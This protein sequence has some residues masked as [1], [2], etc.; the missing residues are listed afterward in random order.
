MNS[1]EY[2]LFYRESIWRYAVLACFA[3]KAENFT[4]MEKYKSEM[5]RFIKGLV[6]IMQQEVVK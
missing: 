3:Q 5:N 6:E 1:W 4:Q 2:R